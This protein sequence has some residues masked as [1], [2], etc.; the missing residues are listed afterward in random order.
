M[1]AADYA[2]RSFDPVTGTE[3]TAE[4]VRVAGIP[5]IRLGHVDGIGFHVTPSDWRVL[6]EQGASL[7]HIVTDNT[8]QGRRQ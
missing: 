5:L 3:V 2:C 4:I 6:M 7:A 1:N 8:T